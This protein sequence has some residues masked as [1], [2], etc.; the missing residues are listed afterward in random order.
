MVCWSQA[1]LR[2]EMAALAMPKLERIIFTCSALLCTY[3]LVTNVMVLQVY[4]VIRHLLYK[5]IKLTLFDTVEVLCPS[6]TF[7]AKM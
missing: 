5:F 6:M 2:G 1:L 3:L 4:D 7:I